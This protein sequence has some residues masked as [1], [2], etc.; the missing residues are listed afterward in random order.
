M[1]LTLSNILRR[2]SWQKEDDLRIRKEVKAADEINPLKEFLEELG[3]S[4]RLVLAF[5]RQEPKSRLGQF[6]L[7]EADSRMLNHVWRKWANRADVVVASPPYATAL[8]YLDTDRLSLSFL[9]LLPAPR[10]Q[11]ARPANDWQPRNHRQN[12]PTVLGAFHF[13]R[14]PL[15]GLHPLPDLEDKDP[16]RNR[17]CRLPA[18]QPALAALQIF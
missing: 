11:T 13:Q 10:A 12:S 2:V 7:N 9:G 17:R 14:K 4:V 1:L 18:A 8:P 6:D 5:L 3:R 16:E 15:A